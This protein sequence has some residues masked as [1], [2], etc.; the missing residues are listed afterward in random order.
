MVDTSAP[1]PSPG[2]L[3]IRREDD[4]GGV[5][6]ALEGELDLSSAPELRRQL[7]EIEAAHPDWILIDL[8]RLTFMD[9]SGLTVVIQAN[10]SAE[11]NGHR[12]SF[13]SASPQVRRL[14]EL[15]GFLEHLTFVT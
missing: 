5:V 8:S 7:R 15:T 1:E 13:R 6:L 3:R 14:F 11:L 10:Q 12:L 9:S 2:I 4:D